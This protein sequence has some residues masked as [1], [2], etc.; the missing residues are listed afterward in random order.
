[1]DTVQ[2]LCS[3]VLDHRRD[4]HPAAAVQIRVA[5]SWH[6]AIGKSQKLYP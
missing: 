2:D 6:S 1:M 4:P 3:V 5:E